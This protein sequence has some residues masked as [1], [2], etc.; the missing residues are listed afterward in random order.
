MYF[1]KNKQPNKK[2]N[3]QNKQ[4]KIN[5]QTNIFVTVLD[6]QSINAFVTLISLKVTA[7]ILKRLKKL[8]YDLVD[9]LGR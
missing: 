6:K 3:K 1:F 4:T 9:I 8:S 5:K 2:T 7:V